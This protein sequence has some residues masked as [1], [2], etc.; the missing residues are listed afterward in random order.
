VKRITDESFGEL[1][2]PLSLGI[3][4]GGFVFAS[5]QGPNDPETGEI[6]VESVREQTV[7]TL[8]NLERVLDA[9]DLSLDDVVKTTAFVTDES[10]YGAFNDGYREVMSEPYPARSVV[11]TGIVQEG[12]KVEIEAIA[13]R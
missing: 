10:Y 2:I 1:S 7:A 4:S 5:G 13:E 12:Q 9:A 8:R 11:V 3:E 6:E